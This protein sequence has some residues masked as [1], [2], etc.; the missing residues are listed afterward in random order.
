M[1]IS[2]ITGLQDFLKDWIRCRYTE[3]LQDKSVFSSECRMASLTGVGKNR[4]AEDA[5]PVPPEGPKGGHSGIHVCGVHR[6]VALLTP[7]RSSPGNSRLF[8]SPTTECRLPGGVP[9]SEFWKTNSE[10]VLRR[11]AGKAEEERKTPQ[12]GG[13]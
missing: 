1:Y 2:G 8:L 3:T 12:G 11:K 7:P 10:A 13:Q 9:K 4:S 6:E 5:K